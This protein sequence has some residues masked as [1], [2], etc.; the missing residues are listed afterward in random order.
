M[1]SVRSQLEGATPRAGGLPMG[2]PPSGPL[3]PAVGG[4][5]P[6]ANKLRSPGGGGRAAIADF[7]PARPGCGPARP[8][9]PAAETPARSCCRLSTIKPEVQIILEKVK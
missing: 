5:S 8:L 1:K 2:H 4:L 6:G 9:N 3:E 7:D